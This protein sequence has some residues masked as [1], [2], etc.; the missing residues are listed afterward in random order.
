VLRRTRWL[1]LRQVELRIEETVGEV[2][3]LPLERPALK[4]M[5]RKGAREEQTPLGRDGVRQLELVRNGH[6]K[7]EA[8][9]RNTGQSC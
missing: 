7:H 1:E 4:F 3:M 8:L 5:L 2:R 9:L 6:E